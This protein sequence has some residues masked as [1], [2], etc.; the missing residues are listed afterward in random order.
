MSCP[1]GGSSGGGGGNSINKAENTLTINGQTMGLDNTALRRLSNRHSTL[2]DA[3]NTL[4]AK[5]RG[6]GVIAPQL[7]GKSQS[8]LRDM[9]KDVRGQKRAI[10][11]VMRTVA[12]EYG[13]PSLITIPRR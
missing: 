7:T 9:L 13:N 8:E 10:G 5:I 1:S 11:K 2:N 4:S 12:N 6:V 3:E